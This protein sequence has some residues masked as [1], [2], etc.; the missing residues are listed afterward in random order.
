MSKSSGVLLSGLG[1]GLVQFAGIYGDTKTSSLEAEAQRLKEMRLQE[2]QANR[3]MIT[4]SF[5]V[6]EYETSQERLGIAKQTATLAQQ[7][8]TYKKEQDL[9]ADYDWKDQNVYGY[10]YT[11][12]DEGFGAGPVQ[13]QKWGIIGQRRIGINK[14][15]PDDIRILNM[16]GT[17]TSGSATDAKVDLLEG[18]DADVLSKLKSDFR[19][20]VG[21]DPTDEEIA[22]A[23]QTGVAN[24][25]IV[26]GKIVDKSATET[27]TPSPTAEEASTTMTSPGAEAYSGVS[28]TTPPPSDTAFWEKEL[29]SSDSPLAISSDPAFVAG[30]KIGAGVKTAATVITDAL[31]GDANL[32]S[33]LRLAAVND[34][35]KNWA[36]DGLSDNEIRAKLE[37]KSEDKKLTKDQRSAFKE[38]LEGFTVAPRSHPQTDISVLPGGGVIDEAALDAATQASDPATIR[39]EFGLG[40]VAGVAGGPSP[41]TSAFGTNASGM[42]D[43]SASPLPEIVGEG[44]GEARGEVVPTIVPDKNPVVVET[45]AMSVVF[46]YDAAKS[47]DFIEGLIKDMQS[48]NISQ[49]DIRKELMTL[50]GEIPKEQANGEF[51]K[52]LATAYYEFTKGSN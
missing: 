1:Q 31:T 5:R 47:K 25:Y 8:F 33:T 23:Y 48:V 9:L 34:L 50:L 35:V 14:K 18:I 16:D 51:A 36:S 6:A 15:D 17:V 7:E 39:A 21:K 12:E 45:D 2:I 49:E 11:T 27:T 4:D 10:Y 13:K 28:V 29:T 40:A 46:G 52:A 41:V 37:E 22:L 38:V 20:L 30:E 24:G 3:N 44:V 26:N 42:E 32:D 43:A 19:S